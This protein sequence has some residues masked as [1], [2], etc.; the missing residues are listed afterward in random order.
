MK[1]MAVAGAR[2]A[3]RSGRTAAEWMAIGKGH[4]LFA[5]IPR[6]HFRI[7]Q[8]RRRKCD[9]SA[10]ERRGD[11]PRRSPRCGRRRHREDR[12]SS[13]RRVR[14]PRAGADILFDVWASTNDKTDTTQAAKS[15]LD[16]DDVLAHASPALRVALELRR[17]TKCDDVKRLLPDAKDHADERATRRLTQLGSRHG[18]GFLGLADC[19]PCIRQNDD[20]SDASHAASGRPAPKF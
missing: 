13:S 14:S 19:F 3:S 2:S 20:L 12:R 15:L 4:A 16:R 5:G 11:A 6:Q 18:C 17:A 9:P 10:H 7:L 1:A 8:A